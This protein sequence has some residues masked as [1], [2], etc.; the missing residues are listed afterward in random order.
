VS[1][2][3][4]LLI[5]ARDQGFFGDQPIERQI[6]HAKGFLDV[7]VA[8][9]Q[10]GQPAAAADRPH[11]LA[12]SLTSHGETRLLDLGAGGGLPGLVLGLSAWPF[13]VRTLLLDGSVRRAEWLRYAV[14]ELDLAETV[15]V[16]E[17]RAEIA[18][19]VPELRQRQSVVVARS[20]GR[21]GVTAECAA[22]FLDVGGAL[23]VSEPPAGA[24]ALS[25][26]QSMPSVAPEAD[27]ARFS[28]AEPVAPSSPELADRWPPARLAELGF[29]PAAEWRARGYRYAVMWLDRLCPERYPRRNGIP[30]K[31]PLF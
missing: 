18:G 22:P 12:R 21:P 2:L 23:V 11:S 10:A 25:P 4:S 16:I 17:A 9:L 14:T 7:C 20:F 26:P 1:T 6:E 3:K 5:E 19:R 8:A 28:G 24:R 31:R 29:A 30:A 27:A 15:E 13:A